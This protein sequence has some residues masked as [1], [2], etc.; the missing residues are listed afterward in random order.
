MEIDCKV[1][2]STWALSKIL[3][4]CGFTQLSSIN[5]H[6]AS[7]SV[8]QEFYLNIFGKFLHTKMFKYLTSSNCQRCSRDLNFETETSPK[9]PRLVVK[10]CALCRT[11][12]K[13]FP[14]SVITTS[15]LN[16]FFI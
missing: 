11:L 10:I 15:K 4:K 13:N 3:S 8:Q 6:N 1:V 9:N 2:M 7:V 16:C 14:K 12:R 5:Y